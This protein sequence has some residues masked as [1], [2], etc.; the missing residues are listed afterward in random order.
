MKKYIILVLALSFSF[1]SNAQNTKEDN[2]K[3]GVKIVNEVNGEGASKGLEAAFKSV[4]PDMADYII[5]YGF[6]E[7]YNRKGIDFKTKELLIIASLTTQ[8]NAKSQLK[9]H[10]KA[11]LNLGVTPNEISE[12]MILLSLYTGFPA[13]NNGIFALKEVLEET[14]STAS[15]PINTTQQLVKNWELD[16]FSMPESIVAS[17]TENWLYVSNVNHNNK[18]YIS[19]ISKDGKV[20]NYK[21]VTGLNS[22]AGLAF[23]QD[24]LYVGDGKELHIINVKNGKVVNSITSPDVVSL[25]DVV[26]SK[27]GQVF[28]SDIASG[29]IFTL[30]NNKLEVWFQTSEIK[31]PNG[32][33]IQDNQLVIAD[34]GAELSQTIT[35]SN[36]GSMY[37]V[38][39]TNK[40]YQIIT[41]AYKL[42][43]LDGVTS[44]NNGYLVS[45]N[46]TGEL[47][48]INSNEKKLIGN[49]PK[50]LAD[51][52][53]LDNLLYTPL[54]FSNKIQVYNLSTDSNISLENWK[55]INTKEEYLKLAANNFYGDKDGQSVAT[56]DGQIFGVFGGK[57]LTGTWDWKNNFFTRTSKI[58]DIDLGYDELVIEVTNTKMRLTLK[59]GKGMTVVYNKK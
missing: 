29:K 45:S 30:V 13:A 28:I 42:G 27:N 48:F 51:I 47:F 33:F 15:N 11:A 39:I 2:Y 37:S 56:H 35:A 25:N 52:S 59:Q 8:A 58:G 18:G 43:G 36:F 12:T 1:A 22:P 32:L 26:V 7:I 34:Y 17:P 50:G 19:K 46:T 24:K 21:W 53:I 10:I 3:R 5:G 40:S 57:V 23:Y 9:S 44:V 49:F 16:G 20:D 54:I 38:N 55:R 6:G 31:H 4:S 14:R 41:S